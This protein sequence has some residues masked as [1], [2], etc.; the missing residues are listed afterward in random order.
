MMILKLYLF[1]YVQDDVYK[2]MPLFRFDKNKTVGPY[3]LLLFSGEKRNLNWI[4]T[5]GYISNG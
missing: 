4:S 5:V 2:K 1:Q 3:K